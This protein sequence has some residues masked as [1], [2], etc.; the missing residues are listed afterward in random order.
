VSSVSSNSKPGIHIAWKTVTYRSVALLVLAVLL[1]IFVGMRFAFPQF[2]ES[3]IRAADS[4]GTK[5]LEVVA[6]SRGESCEVGRRRSSAGALHGAR[7][8]GAGEEGEQQQLGNG[9]LQHSAGKGRCRADQFGR[10]GQDCF[11]RW[12]ELHIKQD[13]LIVIEENSTNDQQQTNVSV[14]VSTGTVDLATATFVQ[15]SRSQVVGRAH[16]VPCAG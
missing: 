7:R 3:G 4:L 15:G 2:T 6:G 1:V 9:R 13:S 8:H 10:H 16:G 14:A 5:L 12:H 11:Q